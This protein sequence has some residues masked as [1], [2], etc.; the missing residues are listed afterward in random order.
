MGWLIASVIG[1]IPAFIVMSGKDFTSKIGEKWCLLTMMIPLENEMVR[2]AHPTLTF[3]L[4]LILCFNFLFGCVTVSDIRNS[5]PVRVMSSPQSPQKI[6]NCV[7]YET[8]AEAG[9]W[10]KYWD[11]VSITELD[12]VYKISVVVNTITSLRIVGELTIKPDA[13]GGSL[14]E[15]RS[16]ALVQGGIERLWSY[17]KK[18]ADK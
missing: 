7:G 5:T 12:G 8:Q 2:S 9:N 15:Y 13:K 3:L 1:P 18:C 16:L 14:I 17:V 6:A 11:I 10:N 4:I